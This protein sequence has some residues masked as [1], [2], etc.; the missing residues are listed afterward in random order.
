MM[1]VWGMEKSEWIS[2]RKRKKK[3]NQRNSLNI[4]YRCKCNVNEWLGE[5]DNEIV[6]FC[7]LF[8][9][10]QRLFS[11]QHPVHN[12]LHATKL[13]PLNRPHLFCNLSTATCA[14]HNM[15]YAVIVD[16]VYIVQCTVYM[17]VNKNDKWI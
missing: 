11:T 5:I 17:E 8:S 4:E 10:S 9:K 15:Y 1:V 13:L 16:T 7:R 14:L 2:K 6:H 12:E 3:K